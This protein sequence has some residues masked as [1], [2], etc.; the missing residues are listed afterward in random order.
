MKYNNSVKGLVV[1]CQGLKSPSGESLIDVDNDP[2]KA[3]AREHA[4]PKAKMF[5]DEVM[6]RHDVLQPNL[7]KAKKQ[8]LDNRKMS[9]VARRQPN[10]QPRRD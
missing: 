3:M 10:H 9:T 8:E 4:K 1:L 5:T 2:W 7:S 6:R